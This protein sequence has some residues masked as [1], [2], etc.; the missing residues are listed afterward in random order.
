[1]PFVE[2][3]SGRK[4]PADL[5]VLP[6]THTQVIH[7]NGNGTQTQANKPAPERVCGERKFSTCSDAGVDKVVYWDFITRRF[8]ASLR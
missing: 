2:D 1:M 5:N 8:L 4:A 6:T 7:S 3:F